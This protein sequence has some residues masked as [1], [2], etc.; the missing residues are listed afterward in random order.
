MVWIESVYGT[1]A[2]AAVCI[3]V[4]I[5]LTVYSVIMRMRSIDTDISDDTTC[6]ISL[7]KRPCRFF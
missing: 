3:V 4:A 1:S 7:L 5:I 6:A 2:V